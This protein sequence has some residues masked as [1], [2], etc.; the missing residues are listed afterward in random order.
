MYVATAGYSVPKLTT[1][2]GKSAL[3]NVAIVLHLPETAEEDPLVSL[4]PVARQL[5]LATADTDAP[6][7]ILLLD[8]TTLLP[9]GASAATVLDAEGHWCFQL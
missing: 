2:F 3:R 6:P 5:L 1:L 4:A 7:A 9:D 8:L